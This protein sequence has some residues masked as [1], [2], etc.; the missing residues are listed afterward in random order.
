[1]HSSNN[2]SDDEELLFDPVFEDVSDEFNSVQSVLKWFENWKNKKPE[3]YV[4]CY[5][6]DCIGKIMPVFIE[7]ELL[8]GLFNPLKTNFYQKIIKSDWFTKILEWSKSGE[9][10][11]DKNVLN[12]TLL[13]A[14]IPF[15]THFVESVWDVSSISES[16]ALVS[17]IYKFAFLPGFSG[18]QSKQVKNLFEK[19][20]KTIEEGVQKDGFIPPNPKNVAFHSRQCWRAVKIVESIFCFRGLLSDELVSQLAVQQVMARSLRMGLKLTSKHDVREKI[21][22]KLHGIL[23]GKSVCDYGGGMFMDYE[24]DWLEKPLVQRFFKDFM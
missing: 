23:V 10:I 8:Q 20:Q 6:A 14:I 13:R 17:N 3:T 11:S 5:T 22:Q 16:K 7:Y 12:V 9:R 24:T 4:Q 2:S 19:I 15:I 21:L 1:M 18:N